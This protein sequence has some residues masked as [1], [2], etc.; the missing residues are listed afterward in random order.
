MFIFVAT[1]TVG[2]D[3]ETVGVRVGSRATGVWTRQGPKSG[4]LQVDFLV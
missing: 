2:T 4:G 1:V 3:R